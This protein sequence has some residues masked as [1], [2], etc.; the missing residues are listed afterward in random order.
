MYKVDQRW[1]VKRSR[2]RHAQIKVRKEK[3]N[4]IQKLMFN[5]KSLLQNL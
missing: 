2:Y 4:L 1:Q 5:A 3:Q